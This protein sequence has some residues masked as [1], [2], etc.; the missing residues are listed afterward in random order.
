[1]GKLV[2]TRTKI[3][4]GSVSVSSAAVE[5]MMAR[6]LPDL[7]KYTNNVHICIL[8][9][10][11]MSRLLLIS[12]FSKNPEAHVTVVNRNVAN[13][14]ALLDDDLVAGRGG[15]NAKVAPMDEMLDIVA[16]SDVVFAATASKEPIL[17]AANV[18]GREKGV[19][20]VDISV[21][22]NIGADCLEVDNVYS[23]SVDDLKKVVQ[24]NAEKRQ[25][26]VL[27]AK[28]YIVGEV[29]KFKLWQA[30]QGA[31]PYLA[32][33]QT[34]AE[35][36]R[37]S[38]TQKMSVKLSGLHE[39]EREAV[40]KLTKHIIDQLFRPIYYSMK[41]NEEID[42]KRSTIWALK[43]MFKLEPEYKRRLLSQ[44]DSPA[45]LNA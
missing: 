5:L 7:R 15:K 4:K 43:N 27:K 14:Q 41:D 17:T 18:A 40:D 45:Q 11:K 25:S 3:G 36:I 9:A 37:H 38:E 20:L 29:Q 24:A 32:A 8:G 22:R 2:R 21:P 6:S 16:K 44:G 34:M 42:A 33:L 10:G 28:R 26:E 39:K 31:V 13:A 1:M 35:N 12:L 19:M 30:S 23:Y